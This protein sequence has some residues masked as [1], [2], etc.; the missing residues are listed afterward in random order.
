M[1]AEPVELSELVAA[2]ERLIR[3]LQQGLDVD[4]RK[5]LISFVCNTT[6]LEP[7]GMFDVPV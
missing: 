5:F 7:F 1:R 3:E 2:R 6:R 4:E